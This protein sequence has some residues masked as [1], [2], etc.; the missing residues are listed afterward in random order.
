MTSYAFGPFLLLKALSA[1]EVES[2]MI[3]YENSVIVIGGYGKR[4]GPM[5]GSEW[6]KNGDADDDEDP[7]YSFL[8]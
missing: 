4:N 6:T 8:D 1:I 2:G 3:V 5:P 7:K